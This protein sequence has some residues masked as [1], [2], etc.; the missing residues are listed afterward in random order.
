M[1]SH[2]IPSLRTAPSRQL[3]LCLWAFL[4]L[5][6]TA[7]T[8]EVLLG[9]L[10]KVTGTVASFDSSSQLTLKSPL[11]PNPLEI[12]A[13]SVHSLIFPQT[14]SPLPS[15]PQLLYL[16]NGDQW[17]VEIIELDSTSLHYRPAWPATL[18]IPRSAL[19]S[20]HFDAASPQILYSGPQKNDWEVGQA[21]K[22]ENDQ[23]VSLAW[24]PAH[25]KIES[26]PDRYVID[27]QVDWTGN[28]GFKFLFASDQPDGNSNNDAY[29]LQF[30]SAGLELKRQVA[31]TRKYV[32]L[33]TFFDLT[34]D[35]W[36]ENSLKFTIRVDR[37]NRIL[38]LALNGKDI[39]RTIIDPQE[40][41]PIPHG[42]VFSFLSTAGLDDQHRISHIRFSS[43][44]SS[45]LEARKEKRPHTDRDTLYD[46][47]SNRISGKLVSIRPGNPP[48][49]VFENPHAPN[50]QPLTAQQVAVIH[51]NHPPQSLTTPCF[52]VA[53]RHQGIIHIPQFILRD[54]QLQ[55]AHPL[56]GSI[57]IPRDQ[58]LSIQKHQP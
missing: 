39:R 1:I 5:Q 38:Q 42:K 45:S 53:L 3:P 4:S 8:E 25:R 34:P 20:L 31:H 21:W 56:L 51:L 27:F 16:T 54:D 29:F 11:S 50:P 57:S 58:I 36:E 35:Q 46:I 30:N 52:R 32:S 17:P 26:L 2:L 41:G 48:S 23:L 40:T 12:P 6:L 37:S 15:P 7:W 28:A 10:G 14:Q 47:D 33:A 24:G 22:W 19:L 44:P 49:I 18:Q 43:W 13:S 55:A 9:D